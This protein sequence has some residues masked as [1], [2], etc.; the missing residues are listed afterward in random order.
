MTRSTIPIE[1][2]RFSLF[3][4]VSVCFSFV[5]VCFGLFQFVSVCVV[6]SSGSEVPY[7]FHF[8]TRFDNNYKYD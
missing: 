4:F 3:Q 5:S 2:L 8:S 7:E 6:L 1:Y